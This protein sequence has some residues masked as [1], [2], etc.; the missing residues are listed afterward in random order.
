MSFE[1]TSPPVEESPKANLMQQKRWLTI[2]LQLLEYSRRLL[3]VRNLIIASVVSTFATILLIYV[4]Y[5]V[6]L[7]FTKPK[8]LQEGGLAY[9]YFMSEFVKEMPSFKPLENSVSYYF[10]FING[11]SVPAYIMRY[12]SN[13]PPDEI[14][15]YYRLYFQILNYTYIKHS[16]DSDALAMFRNTREEFAVF[17]AEG[18]NVNTVSIENFQYD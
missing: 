5:F 15:S 4:F 16:I 3:T 17:V 6:Q 7:V 2:G 8:Q 13:A 14:V 18:E 9:G 12:E 11:A 1:I 10:N